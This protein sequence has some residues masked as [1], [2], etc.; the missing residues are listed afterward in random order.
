MSYNKT[1]TDGNLGEK[2]HQHLLS[3]G[4]ET[5]TTDLLYVDNK[6]KILQIENHMA[7][8]YK[9]IGMDLTDDSLMETP[10][11]IAKMMVLETNWGLLPENFPKNTTI[12]NKMQVDEM[13]TVGEIPVSST[14][15]HHRSKYSWGGISCLFT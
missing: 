12:K 2:I 5:P 7:E 15:E 1:K 14:C 4:L 11:R 10:K 13:V 8:I 3:L 6:D 9:I